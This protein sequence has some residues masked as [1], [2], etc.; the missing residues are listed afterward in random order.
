MAEILVCYQLP[1]R[2]PDGLQYEARAYGAAIDH[3]LWEG[4]IEFVP[5]GGGPT[6]RTPRETTQPNRVD[7]AYWATGLTGVYLEGALIRAIVRRYRPQRE[8]AS[9]QRLQSAV[10]RPFQY[11]TIRS[12]PGGSPPSSRR[13]VAFWPR[14]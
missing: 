2:D 9:P 6:L 3:V 1:V 11:H 14:W 5:I 8:A 7:T 4:W 10:G 13:R 12:V